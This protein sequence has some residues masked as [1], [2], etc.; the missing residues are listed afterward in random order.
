MMIVLQILQMH[1]GDLSV[2][3]MKINGELDVVCITVII[4]KFLE[5]KHVSN[6]PKY[7][8][9]MLRIILVIPSMELE[10]FS[11]D[12]GK[13]YL[14]SQLLM[15]MYNHM[16]MNLLLKRTEKIIFLPLVF[17][18]WKQYVLHVAQSLHGQNL[19]NQNHRQIFYNFLK[20]Y[21]QLKSHILTI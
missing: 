6:M 18:S 9:N 20:E 19:Q 3:S 4:K 16:M 5:R 8:I 7:G 21:I 13:I 2:L 15:L 10:D 14:G 11:K 1:V 17:I 12:L